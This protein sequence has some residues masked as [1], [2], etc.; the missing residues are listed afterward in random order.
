MLVNFEALA[1]PTKVAGA[2]PTLPYSY[3][4]TFDMTHML[5]VDY[6]FIPETT[7]FLPLEKPRGLRRRDPR[8][9]WAPVS[10][11]AAGSRSA[12]GGGVRTGGQPW[13]QPRRT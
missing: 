8:F 12:A 11:L 6:D 9:R 13:S 2:D 4:P 10:L 7:H 5:F 1:C 3:L